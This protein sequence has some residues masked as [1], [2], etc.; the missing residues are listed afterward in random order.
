MPA[1]GSRSSFAAPQGARGSQRCRS[2]SPGRG[3]PALP[4]SFFC[5]SLP[6]HRCPCLTHPPRFSETLSQ[7]STLFLPL[8]PEETL[9]TRTAKLC[10]PFTPSAR[11]H[12]AVC[13]G[14]GAEGSSASSSTRAAPSRGGEQLGAGPCPPQPPAK[15]SPRSPRSPPR[16]EPGTKAAG[17]GRFWKVPPGAAPA[18]K[19]RR[20]P[21]EAGAAPGGRSGPGG[22]R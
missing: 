2:S 19:E 20:A 22:A 18:G 5:P 21:A 1:A 12:R 9:K 6:L 4:A 7:I 16:A 14:R 17:A 10:C 11:R 13:A 15:R 3:D 8:E